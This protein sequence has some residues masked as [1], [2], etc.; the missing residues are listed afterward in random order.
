MK[1]DELYARGRRDAESRSADLVTGASLP[2]RTPK[3]GAQTFCFGCGFKHSEPY[4][5]CVWNKNPY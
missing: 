2:E 3:E 1:M 4:E 5:D